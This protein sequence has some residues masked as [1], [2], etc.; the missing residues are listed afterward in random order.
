MYTVLCRLWCC[1]KQRSESLLLLL[2]GG[3]P[4]F[5][6]TPMAQIS[7]P[8]TARATRPTLA[9]KTTQRHQHT[10]TRGIQNKGMEMAAKNFTFR[11]N[12]LQSKGK[13]V[14][15]LFESY[16]FIYMCV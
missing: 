7:V 9:K 14:Y 5:D 2:V 8:Y 13:S 11:S 6:D 16:I 1:E 3:H 15:I 12:L 10:G 4:G